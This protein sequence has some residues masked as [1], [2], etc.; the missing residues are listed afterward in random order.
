VQRAKVEIRNIQLDSF[1]D[2]SKAVF[3]EIGFIGNQDNRFAFRGHP[4]SSYKLVP[5]IYRRP[6]GVD[7]LQH[8][9]FNLNLLE[10]DVLRKIKRN[11]AAYN[12]KTKSDLELLAIAQHHGL[13]TRLLDWSEDFITALYFAINDPS[14]KGVEGCVWCAELPPREG[15]LQNDKVNLEGL[16]SSLLKEHKVLFI[17]PEY[18]SE[19][20]FVQKGLFS[21]FYLDS[22]DSNTTPMPNRADHWLEESSRVVK[23]TKVSISPSAKLVIHQEMTRLGI[24]SFNFFPDLDGF[25][26][27]L[28]EEVWYQFAFDLRPKE[29]KE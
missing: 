21:V 26:Q 5:S 3:N 23:L 9:Y 1:Y 16:Q 20:M 7:S 12:L 14:K 11:S 28:K 17:R 25:F 4:D 24:S 18:T 15:F 13:P 22:I 6:F 10:K 27:S 8:G 19:R 29:G 2:L